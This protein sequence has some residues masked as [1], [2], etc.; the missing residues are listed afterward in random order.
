MSNKF[1]TIYPTDLPT[2]KQLYPFNV[3]IYHSGSD[4]YSTIIHANTP[5][6]KDKL[7]EVEEHHSKGVKIAISKRQKDIFLSFANKKENEI[8]SLK[9]VQKS[10]MEKQQEKVLDSIKQKREDELDAFQLAELD[11]QKDIKLKTSN[12]QDKSNVFDIQTNSE[13]PEGT[14]ESNVYEKKDF[15]KA[16]QSDDFMNLIDMVKEDI[17]LF[18]FKKSD[19]IAQAL[20]F[21]NSLF[22][23]DNLTNRIVTMTFILAKSLGIENQEDLADLII[24]GFLHDIGL[25]Q[26]DTKILKT[27]TL[28]YTPEQEKLYKRHPGLTQHLIRKSGM[29]ISERCLNII[30]DHH[31]RTNG[32]GFPRGKKEKSIEP[33]AQILGIVDHI[34]W[35]AE[36]KITGSKLSVD[37]VI[38]K[39]EEKIRTPGLEFEFESRVYD[40]IINIIKEKK[41]SQAA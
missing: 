18:D 35:F 26:L 34:F 38:R 5:I 17:Q 40:N 9:K 39:L 16:I 19:N 15:D 31:E 25:S 23:E 28:E 32:T 27:P 2:E 14:I 33:L 21:I 24:A 36:G 41:T 29:K 30:L 7:N 12:T 13:K 10:E 6:T 37:K 3:Y 4:K 20:L 8:L 22:Y 1:F 11:I